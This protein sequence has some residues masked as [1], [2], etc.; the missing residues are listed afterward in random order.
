MQYAII[1][2]IHAN[3][4]AWNAVLL[5]MRSS[6]V[7]RIICLGDIVGYGP[8]PAEV[9]QSVHASV[10]Y[11]VLG[12]H[13]A[14][15][16]EKLDPSLF[17]E[18][19]REI[20]LW[21]R[22][23]LNDNAI[24]FLGTFPLS[25]KGESFRCAH[26]DFS[27]PEAFNYV[28]DPEDAIPSWKTVD[29]QL[30]FIGHTHQPA[31][32]L[33]GQSGIPRVVSAQ[34]FVLEPE[35]R[36]LVN[37]GS[38]GSPR[39]G[40]ARASYCI[41][42]TRN[43]SVC[44]RRIPFDLDAYRNALN[45]AGISSKP[46]YFLHHDPRIGTPLLRKLLNFSPAT[47]PEKVVKDVVKVQDLQVLQ[48]SVK[49][50]KLLFSAIL[51][52]GLGLATAV[53]FTWWRFYNRTLDITDTVMTIIS[54][55]TVP[56]DQNMLSIPQV[57]FPP[58]KPVPGWSIHMG[59]KRKQS[60]RVDCSADIG[61]VF[62]LSSATRKD[63]LKLSSPEIRVKPG[64]KLCLETLFK[65][66]N[67]FSGNIAVVVLLTR[68][69]ESGKEV[70]EQ[71]IVKEPN[72]PKQGG[73]LLAKKTFSMPADACSIKFQICGKFTGEAMIRDISLSRKE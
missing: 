20:I 41:F 48:R 59:D 21:T 56:N 36:F 70:V 73:W 61:P 69:P 9:L 37:P 27:G 31:I 3:L 58:G 29:E 72:Q 52:L 26:G 14:V 49:K 67:D 47:T 2:D 46:S 66:G 45:K 51:C 50:W 43:N 13:D 60:A 4:Q 38:V 53:G 28:I 65:K 16:C 32:F 40:E 25:L 10:D 5:D 54:A 15:I 19:A 11:L 7:D 30:L 62:V 44:W 17:N 39:D 63:E 8:N 23:Q 57:S 6:K 33:L 24:K 68:K 34:D 18:S 55:V 64:M 1:S 71:F 12:N 35:K 22:K 42:D